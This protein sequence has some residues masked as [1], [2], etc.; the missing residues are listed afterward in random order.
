[1]NE[2]KIVKSKMK[3]LQPLLEDPIISRHIPKT[4]W[5]SPPILKEMLQ[6]HSTLYVKPDIGRKGNGIIR[7]KA[8][9]D[10][11][12]E[13]SY[14]KITKQLL[15]EDALSEFQRLIS[16]NKK[17]IIQQGIDL[18]T[19]EKC[20]FDMRLL[21]QKPFH[22]WQL[23]LVGGRVATWE[24][25]VVTNVAKGAR[26]LLLEKVLQ[27]NDQ[28]LNAMYALREMID[29]SHQI[30]NILDYHFPL[31]IIGLDMGIDKKGDIWFIEANTNP[32]CRLFCKVNNEKSCQK[33]FE[34]KRQI[35]ES[36]KSNLN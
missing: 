10:A 3:K 1:M 11:K 12:Y 19:Y 2:H 5:Y 20:P 17:Y 16:H 8:L 35:R 6:T 23:T 7:L 30:V 4:E 13:I 9:N 29:L 15:I 25:A 14:A 28:K 22:T 32:D 31:R 27:D 33:Y 36:I 21:M 18:A 24:N 34:A 26:E